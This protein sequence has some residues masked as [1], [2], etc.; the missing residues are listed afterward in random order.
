[1]KSIVKTTLAVVIL[2]AIMI[3]PGEQIDEATGTVTWCPAM[4]L[5]CL[6]VL[7]LCGLALRKLDKSRSK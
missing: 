7:A 6:A 1:M 5:G 4:S 3:G 2:L